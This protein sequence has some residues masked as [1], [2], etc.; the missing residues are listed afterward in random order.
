MNFILLWGLELQKAL[1]ELNN[2]FPPQMVAATD[3]EYEARLLAQ[4]DG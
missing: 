1:S 2:V 3:P 4:I